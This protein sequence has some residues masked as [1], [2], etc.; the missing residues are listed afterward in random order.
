MAPDASDSSSKDAAWSANYTLSLSTSSNAERL[1]R[2]DYA[3]RGWGSRINF[4]LS[5]G[6]KSGSQI[7]LLS[8]HPSLIWSDA[9]Y[10]Q[11][12]SSDDW[13]EGNR[14][15][16]AMIKADM[17]EHGFAP[18]APG[19]GSFDAQLLTGPKETS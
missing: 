19:K 3:K 17:E 15:L 7:P 8:F 10:L 16:D 4:Q 14:I 2:E 5:Y 11:A 18:V 6:L 12:D 1:S 9:A 13:E